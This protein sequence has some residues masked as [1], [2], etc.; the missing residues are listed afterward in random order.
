MKFRPWWLA[1]A[2]LVMAPGGAALADMDL[3]R[4]S[5]CSA[6][7]ALEIKVVGPSFRDIAARYREVEGARAM[8]ISKVRIGGRGNWTDVTGGVPMPP[9]SPR[10]SDEDIARLVD[11]ILG[12]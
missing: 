12:L 1:A 11:Y 10:V 6:C 8:L 3:A 2:A 5:G 7:H 4:A 9:Y